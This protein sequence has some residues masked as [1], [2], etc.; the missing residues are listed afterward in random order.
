MSP[1]SSKFQEI[2][3]FL[4]FRNSEH[5]KNQL[6]RRPR[7]R[8]AGGRI[9]IWPD[10]PNVFICKVEEQIPFVVSSLQ[11]L[12]RC[13]SSFSQ[14]RAQNRE[15]AT[16]HKAGFPTPPW[17]RELE[18]PLEF[19]WPARRLS[20]GYVLHRCL[21]A[22]RSLRLRVGVKLEHFVNPLRVEGDVNEKRRLRR[23]A[24]GPLDADADDNSALVFVADQRTAVVFLG[25]EN[26]TSERKHHQSG[27]LQPSG[28]SLHHTRLP[29]ACRRH[30][31]CSP[32]RPL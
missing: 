21:L 29:L 28:G 22:A 13:T 10:N 23:G 16:F 15:M 6:A 19:A 25:G 17:W 32:P 3:L 18:T 4:G 24:F 12:N 11:S 8:N 7:A 5:V 1:F 14:I 20:R 31:S 30:R 26:D 2:I 27:T 9:D